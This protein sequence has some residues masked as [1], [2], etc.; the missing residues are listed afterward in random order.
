MKSII[1]IKQEIDTFGKD[2]AI[3]DKLVRLRQHHHEQKR[4]EKLQ[5]LK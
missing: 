1:D 4:Q 5:I 3:I 2:Q